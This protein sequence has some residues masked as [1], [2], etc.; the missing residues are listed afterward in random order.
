MKNKVWIVSFEA[1]YKG[2]AKVYAENAEE[3]MKYVEENGTLDEAL[4]Q[5]TSISALESVELA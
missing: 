5:R 2:V 4:S 1:I 3:A